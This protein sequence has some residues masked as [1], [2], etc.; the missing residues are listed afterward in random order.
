MFVAV[1]SSPWDTQTQT[2]GK[3]PVLKIKW[4]SIV[5]SNRQSF[6]EHLFVEDPIKT[7]QLDTSYLRCYLN[8]P[9]GILI[10][11]TEVTVPTDNRKGDERLNVSTVKHFHKGLINLEFC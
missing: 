3:K 11:I 2:G 1:F 8:F 10:L 9:E 4:V 7:V 6:Q 5:R